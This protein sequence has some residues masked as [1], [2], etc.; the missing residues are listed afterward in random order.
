MS[1][2]NELLEEI[3]G[4]DTLQE[5]KADVKSAGKK[6]LGA[7]KSMRGVKVVEQSYYGGTY[8]ISFEADG[9]K[10]EHFK[11]ADVAM[12]KIG[13]KKL[14][15]ASFSHGSGG[16]SGMYI[17]YEVP[18]VESASIGWHDSNYGPAYGDITLNDF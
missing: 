3:G 2:L 11:V 6:A 7:L 8:G 12:R 16:Q 9:G 13:G 18:G 5:G 10:K 15:G 17:D 14:G 4:A 1:K